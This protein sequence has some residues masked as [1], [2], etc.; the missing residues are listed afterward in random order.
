MECPECKSTQT[1]KAGKVWKARQQVQR[2][3]C[4][5]CGRLFTPDGKTKPENE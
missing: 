5:D 3:R 2:Y 1:T 4:S